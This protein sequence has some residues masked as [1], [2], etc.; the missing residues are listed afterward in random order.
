[1]GSM[2][3]SSKVEAAEA[4]IRALLL[5]GEAGDRLPSE[6]ELA[7]LAGVSRVTVRE[8]LDRLWYE[9]EVV[10]RWGA[11]TFIAD[12]DRDRA[13]GPFRRIYV[14]L[15]DISSL[16]AQID[17]SGRTATLMAFAID[18]LVPPPWVQAELGGDG[19]AWRVTRCLAIDETPAMV[20]RDY[21]PMTL[22]G[23]RLHPTEL[24]DLSMD[25]PR[26]LRMNGA[27]V[28][29]YESRVE[30]VACDAETA[31]LLGREPGAPQLRTRQLAI[32][33]TGETVSCA[34]ISMREDVVETTLV[35]AIGS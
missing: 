15:D 16:P 31:E 3:S 20:M 7:E 17:A 4:A 5:D 19:K 14:A 9:G 12:R 29:K 35:R 34:E 10:R 1:M 13:G 30:A 18:H 11:G 25:L 33:D 21:L 2:P 28:V 24:S 27:R 26:F 23:K 6:A 22:R 8:A 32:S